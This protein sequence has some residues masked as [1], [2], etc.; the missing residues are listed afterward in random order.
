MTRAKKFM[1]GIVFPCFK[2]LPS[3]PPPPHRQL[4]YIH[5]NFY[6]LYSGRRLD[7]GVKEPV[8]G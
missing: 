5:L 4:L 1:N 2:G 7:G 8:G 6:L 3:P